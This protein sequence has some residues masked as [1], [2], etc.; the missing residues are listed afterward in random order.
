MTEHVM[1]EPAGVVSDELVEAV[2]ADAAEGGVDL[3]GP[4][5]VLAEIVQAGAGTGPF[6]RNYPIIWAMST[7]IRWV[8]GRVTA[9]TGPLPNRC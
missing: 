2:V 1:A 6:V 9:V 5:G 3:L 7:V 8:M 4:D